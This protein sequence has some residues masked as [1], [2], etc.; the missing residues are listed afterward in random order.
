MMGF[1]MIDEKVSEKV[2]GLINNLTANCDIIGVIGFGSYFENNFRKTSDVDLIIIWKN[3]GYSKKI[4]RYEG[5]LFEAFFYS[6]EKICKVINNNIGY[7][8][9]II[10][11]GQLIKDTDNFCKELI[12]N[13][14]EKMKYPHPLIFNKKYISEKSYEIYSLR[15]RIDTLKNNQGLVEVYLSQLLEQIVELHFLSNDHWWHRGIQKISGDLEAIDKQTAD[16]FQNSLA[17]NELDLRLK[18][19]DLII[20]KVFDTLNLGKLD[21]L[22]VDYSDINW[23]DS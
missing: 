1:K 2:N 7:M 9:R 22:V 13:C 12:L 19:I 10:G 14:V 5:V 20:E 23:D 16:A 3:S 8:V 17:G 6:R 18:S 4:I 15:K 11:E 21:S